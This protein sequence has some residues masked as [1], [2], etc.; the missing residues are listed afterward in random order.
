MTW[1]VSSQND[2]GGFGLAPSSPSDSDMTGA[3]V[4][5]LAVVGRAR[6]RAT[7][8]AVA[9]L[10]ANQNDDGGFGQFRGR[11]SNAQSTAYA[12]QGLVAGGAGGATLTRALAYLRGLQ[13]RDGSVAYSSTSN[14]TPVWVTAQALLALER[15]PL[16]LA[17]VPRRQPAPRA[18][19]APSRRRRRRLPS[20]AGRAGRQKR[21]RANRGVEPRAVG[22]ESGPRR[23]KPRGD[24][25][26]ARPDRRRRTTP[27]R[28]ARASPVWVVR[29][30]RAHVRPARLCGA[31]D[32]AWRRRSWAA[33]RLWHS[34][35]ACPRR[36][37]FDGALGRVEQLRELYEA[38][39]E[40]AVRKDIGHLDEH[41]PA[42]DRRGADAVRGHLLGR[43]AVR[44]QPARR[45][46]PGS[47]PCSTTS[48][49]RSRTPP[50]TAASTRSRTSCQPGAPG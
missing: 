46:S 35:P 15:K 20:R 25:G 7:Q 16:P 45:A 4:Q 24:G 41:V 34:H 14:Q 29:G 1:L 10:R 9:W 19:R 18:K 30:V 33:R 42:A 21:R 5:A 11:S 6:G 22:I 12:V 17:A 26:R 47:S 44:R 39:M 2:D 23:R 38:A 31:A 28:A 50:A 13:R 43:R 32:R 37:P 36:D 3:V 49:S 27:T 40:R 8:R 48:T